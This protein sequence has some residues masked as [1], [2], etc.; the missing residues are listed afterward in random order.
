MNELAARDED[1][2]CNYTRVVK[3]DKRKGDNA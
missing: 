3:L 2:H 1:K